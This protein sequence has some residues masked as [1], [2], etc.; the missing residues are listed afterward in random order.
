VKFIL[1]LLVW[2]HF[3]FGRVV[4]FDPRRPIWLRVGFLVARGRMGF[5]WASHSDI[6]AQLNPKLRAA[7]AKCWPSALGAF[8]GPSRSFT[9]SLSTNSAET[10]ARGSTPAPRPSFSTTSQINDSSAIVGLHV[11]RDSFRGRASGNTART[12]TP[13]CRNQAEGRGLCRCAPLAP[14]IQ[15]LSACRSKKSSS[16]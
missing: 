9:H 12:A 5:G 11:H 14:V 13:A 3:D 1:T 7:H 15:P 2:A 6:A 16:P 10:A 4:F 8:I